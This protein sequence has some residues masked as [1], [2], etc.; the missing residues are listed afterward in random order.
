MAAPADWTELAPGV[1]VAVWAPFNL[2]VGLVVGAERAVLF[3]T[4][5]SLA[6]GLEIVQLARERTELPLGAVNSHSH[7]DHCFGNGAL[8]PDVLWSH[9]LCA[10]HLRWDGEAQQR[11]VIARLRDRDR[12][13]A[14]AI[15]ASPIVSPACL[16]EDEVELDLGGRI[17][18]LAHPGRGHTD[19]DVVAWVGSDRVLFAGDL[20]EEGAPPSFEDSYPLDWPDSL[21]SLLALDPDRIVPGHGAV[22]DA[23]FA[24]A[25]HTDLQQLADL[26]RKGFRNS[27]RP[28]EFDV[29]TAFPG[30]PA[31]TAIRRAYGQLAA[32]TSGAWVERQPG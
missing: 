22:V 6:T 23:G 9:R 10:E 13:V 17:V 21:A 29:D 31:Q 12:E 2:N 24:R 32:A 11:E 14:Q 8:Q 20:V 4:G 3:D 26:S 25:Q 27:R 28:G 5:H 16:L 15:A 18:T 1:F 7:F 30:K 19:N